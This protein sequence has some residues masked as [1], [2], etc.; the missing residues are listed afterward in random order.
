MNKKINWTAKEL[1]KKLNTMNKQGLSIKSLITYGSFFD[2]YGDRNYH[3]YASEPHKGYLKIDVMERNDDLVADSGIDYDYE[4]AC[5]YADQIGDDEEYENFSGLFG[6][7]FPN[8]FK[9][10]K[11]YDEND[12][13][14]YFI[15]MIINK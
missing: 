6:I 3:Y 1:E 15:K 9:V 12:C 5:D 8:D 14:T 11:E 10:L 7:K 13:K 4:V 2:M